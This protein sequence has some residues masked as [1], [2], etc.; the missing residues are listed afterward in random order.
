MNILKTGLL[1]AGCSLGALAVPALAQDKP[2]GAPSSDTPVKGDAA[3]KDGEIVVTGSRVVTNGNN[4]PTPVTV[5]TTDQL[6]KATPSN[7]PDGLNK[8]PVFNGSN[9]QANP[10]G[11]GASQDSNSA[12]NFL[13][14]RGIGPARNLILF[15]G[16][17]VPPSSAAGLVDVNMLPQMLIQRVDVVTGGVSAVYGSDAVTGVVNFVVDR[18]FTGLKLQAQAGI[19]GYGDSA[20]RRL[21]AAAGADLFGGRGHIEASFE[22]YN[23]D[24]LSSNLDRKTSARIYTVT[25]NGTTASPYVL[26]ADSRS[27]WI[28]FNGRPLFSALSGYEFGQNGTLTPVV[29]GTPTS[30][31]F[32]QSGGSGGWVEPA[33]ITA[34][35]K[36]NQAFA[37]FDYNLASDIRFYAQGSY[38]ETRNRYALAPF[39]YIFN[40]ISADNAFLPANAKTILQNAG[41]P[42]FAF[43]KGQRNVAPLAVD[44]QSRNI[45]GNVGIA[46]KLFGGIDFDLSYTHG[47]NRL[48]YI[49]RNNTNSARLAAALDAVVGPGGQIVCNVTLTNPGLYPGCV[50]INPFGPTSESAA[51]LAYVRQDTNYVLT[52]KM[53]DIAVNLV[54]SPFRTWAGPVRMALS[55]EYRTQTLRSVTSNLPV[56]VDCTGLRFNCTPGATSVFVAN[57]AGN[58]FGSQDVKE[59]ALEVDVPLLTNAPLARSI[60]L[61]G[62]VRY[63]DYKTSG[64]AW[65]WKVGLDWHLTDAL[66]LRATRS[67][68]LRA[69][70]L[71]DL[72]APSRLSRTGYNDLH[73]GVNAV[74]N[75]LVQG[76]PNLK[77]EVADTLTIGGVFKPETSFGFS[78]AIDYYRISIRDAITSLSGASP[79]VQQQCDI[80]GG[81]SPL[82]AL[83][84]RPLPYSN[85]TA[86][87]YP[88]ALLVQNLN[89]S[90][91]KSEGVDAELNLGGKVAGGRLSFRG[92]V[93]Y[94]PKL[95]TQQTP[96]DLVINSAG[97]A[98]QSKW[99]ATAFV[100]Y[101]SGP[102]SFSLQERWRSAQKQS[103]DPRLVFAIPDVPAVAYTDI[104]ATFDVATARTK[105][106]FFVS[107]QNL[108]NNAPPVYVSPASAGAPGYA[109]PA[110]AGDD[111]I[112]RYFTAGIR[113]KF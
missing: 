4:F 5:V 58:A 64:G 99:R 48:N 100:D 17:R 40:V 20:S 90:S 57:V 92:L 87:N 86:A 9:N 13:N 28:N 95:E 69:P 45:Y 11:G 105:F 101:S 43:G 18:K 50:P 61:S 31:A 39:L 22:S 47:E 79:D 107:V 89:V 56:A 111:I 23:S 27:L 74:V 21:G 15:D 85:T 44:S 10:G 3:T 71:F 73:T 35:L 2:T 93:S 108:F 96:G 41:E 113:A 8:L 77:P 109:F 25:G 88:T 98:G 60:N 30:N 49:T 24:G 16:H 84:I 34:S 68:D 19:S 65:T 78:L 59:A 94:Q 62:A 14:L 53:D 97:A 12:G 91:L 6:S 26:T 32:I 46:G 33:N 52:N 70:T 55:A 54:G 63:A 104:G 83:T 82:C 72:F 112:G 110:V 102:V 37:R 38:T 66:R 1:L 76:N 103:G 81:T 80:S 29:P 51:A 42:A 67:R 36:S 7:I 75:L 106:Q